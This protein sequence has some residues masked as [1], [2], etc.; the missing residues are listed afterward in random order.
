M[1]FGLITIATFGLITMATF[2]LITFA[3][4]GSTGL[5]SMMILVTFGWTIFGWTILGSMMIFVIWGSTILA[6]TIFGSITTLVILGST[7]LPTALGS[8]SFGLTNL[9]PPEKTPPV[10]GLDAALMPGTTQAAATTSS[11]T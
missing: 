9:D 2:G 7:T 4:L 6:L 8:I 1:I 11:E 5:G 10:L 3:T